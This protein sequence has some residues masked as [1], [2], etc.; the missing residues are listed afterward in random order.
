MKILI[1]GRERY[2]DDEMPYI[3][4]LNPDIDIFKQ[5]AGIEKEKSEFNN[6]E[7]KLTDLIQEVNSKI[8]NL[9]DG[10]FGIIALTL[11][12]NDPLMWS[13]YADSHRGM[14]IEY[15]FDE[16]LK[17][18][19]NVKSL[20]FPI[21]Y[22]KNRISIDEN[23]LDKVDMRDFDEQGKEDITKLFVKGL[24]SKHNCWKTE[25]EWRSIALLKNGTVDDRKVDSFNVRSVSF[26]NMM[27]RKMKKALCELVSE[28]LDDS[29]RFYEMVNDIE[30]YTIKRVVYE[31]NDCYKSNN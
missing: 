24:Y 16:Y 10:K 3:D 11:L 15:S 2:V 27:H 13:H 8:F 17:D 19:E 22:S 26:G 20:V 4:L 23:I 28:K 6:M 1:E 25:K 29:T 5:L 31:K 12:D 30:S 9:I 21:E 7:D 14:C 18:R